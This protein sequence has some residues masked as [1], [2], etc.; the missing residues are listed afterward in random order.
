MA[1][2]KTVEEVA[3]LEYWDARYSRREDSAYEW[4]GSYTD[5]RSFFDRHIPALPPSNPLIVHLGCGRSALP[6]DLLHYGYHQLCVDF[7][8]VL[9]EEMNEQHKAQWRLEFRVMDVRDMTG[10]EES[11]IGIEDSSIDVAIDKG[12]LDAMIHGS[13]RSPPEEVKGNTSR[14]INEVVRVLKPGGLFLYI[15]YRQP[16]FVKPMLERKEWD[17]QWEVLNSG[18]GTFDYHGFVIKKSSAEGTAT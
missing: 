10:T 9:I 14:Y 18:E 16:H 17:V 1:D 15:T 8:K 5:F 12:T 4:F 2:A 6:T 11:S 3:T 13:P 7:S